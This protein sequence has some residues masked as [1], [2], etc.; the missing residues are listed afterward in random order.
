WMRDMASASAP[1]ILITGGVF[2]DQESGEAPLYDVKDLNASSDGTKLLFAMRAP[3][4]PDLD[5]DEQPTWNI[6]LYDQTQDVLSRIISSDLTAEAGQDISPKFLPDGRILFTSTRQR[7]SGAIL[8][9]EG[10]PQFPAFEEG[11]DNP[12]LTLHVMNDDGSDVH[13]ISYNQSHDMDPAVMSDGRVVYSRWDQV[14]N[15]D[16]ISLYSMNPDGS[17]QQLL[18]GVHSHETGPN[19]ERVEFTRPQELPDGRILVLLRASRGQATVGAD[20]VAIDTKAYIDDEMPTFSNAGLPNGAQESLVSGVIRLDGDPSPRGRFASVYPLNDGSDRFVAA[21]S[22]CRLLD[23]IT[24]PQAPRIVACTDELLDAGELAEA[25][26]LYG[27]WMFDPVGGTQQ[28]IVLPEEDMA[29][30]DAVVMEDRT[31]PLV[32]LDAQP[33]VDVDIDLF[34]EDIGILHIRSV[35]DFA[36]VSSV[37]LAALSDPLQTSAAERPARFL[38]IVKAVSIPDDDLVDLNG[39]SFGRSSAQLM[40]EIIGYADIEPDGSVKVKI[41][42]NIAFAVSVLDANGRRISP[43]H[44]NWLQLRPGEEVTCSGCH[45]AQALEPHGRRDAEAPSANPGAAADGVPFPNTE[46]ALFAN[47]GESMAEL[48]T[49]INGVPEPDPNLVFDD[50]WTDPNARAKDVG[51][52]YN[53]NDLQTPAP[54]EPGCITNWQGNCRIVV[55][56]EAIIHPIFAVDRRVFDPNDPQ[57]LLADNTCNTCHSP[58]DAMGVVQIPAAQLDLTDGLS[59]DQ[60]DHFNSYR[61]LLFNDQEQEILNGVLLDTLVQAVDGAGNP[62]FQL[63]QNGDLILDA[64]GQPIPVLVNINVTPSLS[65]GG[66]NVSPRFMSLFSPQGSHNGRLAEVE[67]KLLSEWLDI[68]AQYYNNPFDVPQ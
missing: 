48:Y 44:Q 61:E 24:D 35:Y 46:P 27:V 34:D 65:V 29:F 4:D 60:P 25:A 5:D 6:W 28:P 14:A 50:V 31:S 59:S 39:R 11:R 52:A 3:E 23:D 10:K 42:A 67:L 26:P 53:Y 54:I 68:G 57:V 55:N 62:L 36:G 17:D 43:R 8:L 22:Q 13:Q 40:R 47:A 18:Y 63:D 12:A 7:Q 2:P 37:D 66:A 1:E 41:P 20:L 56:Y 32:L 45:T 30:T 64:M 15:L 19:G 49:R 38:R 9:D 16:R 58:A 33:G 51:F 21:W